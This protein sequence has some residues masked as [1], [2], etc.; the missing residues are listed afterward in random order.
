LQKEGTKMK[1]V[2][3][4]T[5][6]LAVAVM[7]SAFACAPKPTPT[8][9]PTPKPVA[10]TAAPTTPPAAPGAPTADVVRLALELAD[11][12]TRGEK[13]DY[14]GKSGVTIGVIMPQ[15]DNEGF[16]AIY[17]GALSQAIA[18]DATVTTLDARL[19]VDTQLAMIEDLITRK[20]NAIVFV[21]VDSAALSTGVIKANQAGIPIVAMDRSTES[22]ELA[23]LVESD[24]VAHGAKGADLMAEAAAK[25]GI[26]LSDLKVLELW[27][28]QA[29]SAGVERHQGFSTRAKELGINIVAQFDAKWD[30]AKANAAV[31][32]A[33]AAHPD[34][35]AIF[36]PSGCAYYAGVESAL[37]SLGKWHRFGEPGHI[38]I[39]SVDGCPAPLDA[40]RN[41]YIY[42]DAAQRLV[43]M[44]QKAMEAAFAVAKGQ[45]LPQKVIRLVPDPVTPDNVDDPVHWANTLKVR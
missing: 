35:N 16:R 39:T 2:K 43:V 12:A 5:A 20:V 9:T 30:P 22:G 44:G 15:L 38:L 10:P 32:D 33:F 6:L 17:I 27:G 3:L 24:N 11:K 45:T 31:L 28:D 23:A 29:T 8:P 40:I 25:A 14:T 34:I 41:G 21:P 36:M 4:L 19:S 13:A 42:G 26:K 7:V 1:G 37:K 18:L